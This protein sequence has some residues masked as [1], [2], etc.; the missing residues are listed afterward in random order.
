MH[1]QL[2]SGLQHSEDGRAE[3]CLKGPIARATVRTSAVFG[4]RLSLQVITLLLVTRMLGPVAYG[5]FAGVMGLAIFLGAF[6]GCGMPLEQMRA[7]ARA[8]GPDGVALPYALP[9]ILLVGGALLLLFVPVCLLFLPSESIGTGTLLAIGAAELLLQ[10]VLVLFAAERHGRGEMARA[11]LMQVF[12]L[13]LRTLAA[14]SV[15]LLAPSSPLPVYAF[16]YALASFLALLLCWRRVLRAPL[17]NW[18]LP[19]RSE[20][21][22]A[23]GYA[24]TEVSRNGPTELDKSIAARSLLPHDAGLYSAGARITAA[25][26]LPVMAMAVSALPRLFR[27]A[28]GAGSGRLV[29]VMCAL[30]LSFGSAMAVLLWLTAPSLDAVLGDAY[31]DVGSVVRGLCVVVPGLALRIVIGNVLMAFGQPWVR[32]SIESCGVAVLL[33][34]GAALSQS[35]GTTGMTLAL[36]CSEW[37]MALIGGALLVRHLVI[38]RKSGT[39]TGP[40]EGRGL[41]N[42]D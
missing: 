40:G 24:A 7:S 31:G 9:A 29:A 4:L 12:P 25:V 35:L 3:S 6:S 1:V 8:E 37:G 27:D 26:V 28:G 22:S 41:G 38:A 39:E 2:A 30:A 13:A 15:V 10:P 42:G 14:G 33:F 34:T 20:W 32:V 11:Q 19:R 23:L 18:R 16:A 5:A 36:A 21:R 17:G